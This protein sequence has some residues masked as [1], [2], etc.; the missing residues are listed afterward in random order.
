MRF[1]SVFSSVPACCCP[2]LR[3]TLCMLV[4]F[5]LLNVTCASL[6]SQ[7]S[8]TVSSSSHSSSATTS[9]TASAI[10]VSAAKQARRNDS[11][12]PDIQDHLQEVRLSGRCACRSLSFESRFRQAYGS[13]RG[14]V[15]RILEIQKYPKQFQLLEY[16][17]RSNGR[18]KGPKKFA[19]GRTF[20][21]R[22]HSN[23]DLCGLRLQRNREY[24]LNLDNPYTQSKAGN[25]PRGTVYI[26]QCSKNY[27]WWSL[28]Q[29]QRRF[30][31]SR[32]K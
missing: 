11:K 18:F 32:T 5:M 17:V 6:L 26:N 12:V 21:I 29:N 22:A 13:V 2:R 20:R 8:S 16:I 30:L 28:S 4:W 25:I 14:V 31:L 9:T 27:Y 15:I 24:L 3:N 7:T 10:H 23:P 1:S 19:Q